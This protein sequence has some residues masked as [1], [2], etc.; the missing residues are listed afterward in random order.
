A[1]EAIHRLARGIPR[2]TNLLSEHSLISAFVDQQKPVSA[3][4]VE[5][6]ARD[7][8][9]NEIDPLAQPLPAAP[10]AATN[11]Q[12]GQTQIVESLLQALNTVMERLN[13]AEALAQSEK[14][15]S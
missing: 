11:G 2:V 8:G 10:A 7:F 15:K 9:L 14:E 3:E 12:N 4:I 6:V 5:E 13:R 1:I